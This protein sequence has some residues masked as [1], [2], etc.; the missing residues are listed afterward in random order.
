MNP[1][2][3]STA[4]RTANESADATL[5]SATAGPGRVIRQARERARLGIEELASMT[6]LARSTLEA[7]ERDDFS[8][9]TEAVYVRGYYR[10]CAKVLNLPEAELIAAD[11]DTSLASG[12][13][14]IAQT[15]EV[16]RFIL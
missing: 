9:L 3:A 8:T 13:L 14:S 2:P 15:F 11:K 7:L 12:L 4:P 1:D 16:V 5:S 10:K 6:R